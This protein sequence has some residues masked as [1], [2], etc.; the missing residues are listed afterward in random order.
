MIRTGRE[1]RGAAFVVEH[2]YLKL[3]PLNIGSDL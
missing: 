3:Y 1:L 2:Q